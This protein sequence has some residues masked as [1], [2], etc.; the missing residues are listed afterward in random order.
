MDDD[1]K[2]TLDEIADF[3]H[4]VESVML[5]DNIDV[6]SAT[7]HCC[8]KYSVDYEIVEKLLSK[9]L[10]ALLYDEAMERNLIVKHNRLEI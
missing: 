9:R 3:S 2:P 8:E 6:I 4:K 10:I 7:A 1:I 5:S